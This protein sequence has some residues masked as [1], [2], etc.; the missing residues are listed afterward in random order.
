MLSVTFASF[1]PK[2][3]STVHCHTKKQRHETKEKKERGVSRHTDERPD[4]LLHVNSRMDRILDCVT[5]FE[6][7]ATV[8]LGA[9]VAGP[10]DF[11]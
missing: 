9:A 8:W 3:A 6:T 1:V 4:A 10:A 5:G 7:G 2:L 11:T